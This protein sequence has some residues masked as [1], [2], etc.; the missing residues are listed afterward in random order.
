MIEDIS[1]CIMRSGGNDR[2]LDRCINS[3]L[4][5]Q[6]PRFEILVC[7]DRCNHDKV[8][9][10]DK[11]EW[12]ENGERNK[13]RNL[14]CSHSLAEFTVLLTENI[15]LSDGWY[16]AIKH[17]DCFDVCGSRIETENKARAVDWAYRVRLGSRSYPCPLEYDEWT[18]KAYVSGELMLLRKGAWERVKFDET[19]AYDQWDDEDFCLRASKAGFRI[20]VFPQAKAKYDGGIA[21]S[22]KHVSFENSEKAVHEFRRAF[23]AGKEAFKSKDYGLALKYLTKAAEIAPDDLATLTYIGWAH[24][25]SCR[26]ERAI[27]VFNEAVKIDPTNHS[28]FRGRGWSLLQVRDYEKAVS[29]FEKALEQVNPHNR[30]EWVETV[31]GLAW[32]HYHGA[33]YDQAIMHFGALA[34][35]AHE[36]ERALLQDVYRGLGWSSCRM[37]AFSDAAAYFNKAI[38]NIDRDNRDLLRDAKRGLRLVSAGLSWSNS[39]SENRAAFSEVCVPVTLLQNQRRLSGILRGSFVSKL[40]S[41][42]RKFLSF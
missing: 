23:T 16:E 34:D 21:A 41:L 36:R 13:M 15:E 19:L 5:Q 2:A 37:N 12:F 26:Y 28:V 1:F 20:G 10:F 42:T 29:D 7:G 24:Y 17:A 33:N 9:F 27:G 6:V 30:D 11:K 22:E 3:I 35:K 4:K 40:R 18:T 25:F 38:S 8:K 32:S 14:L 39:S 31:R